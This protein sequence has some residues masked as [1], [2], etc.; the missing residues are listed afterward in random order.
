MAKKICSKD[1]DYDEYNL[2]SSAKAFLKK[3]LDKNPETRI[4]PKDAII[5]PFIL[6]NTQYCVQKSL[7]KRK[8][9]KAEEDRDSDDT[10]NNTP[11]RYYEDHM[12][13]SLC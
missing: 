8:S 2:S 11:T 9:Y 10:D 7:S 3:L 6:K 4:I 12:H 5:H 1:I 13:F